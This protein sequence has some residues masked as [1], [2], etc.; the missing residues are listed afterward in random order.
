MRISTFRFF[1]VSYAVLLT[2]CGS[3]VHRATREFADNLTTAILNQDDPATV[4]DGVPSYL[5]LID[6][7]I[8]G[9]P[10]S[11]DALLAGA[12]LYGAY[13]SGFVDSTARAQHLSERAY[14][15]AKRA[16]CLREKDLC[17]ALDGPFD[18][19]QVALDKSNRGDVETIYGFASAWAGRIQVNTG[20]WNAIAD[21]PKLQALLTRL[22]NI[23]AQYDNGGAY[24]Y[25]GVI[26]SI[27]P[28]SLGGKPE[29]GK[30][31]FEKALE[32]SHGKNQ[33]VRV[34]Y[35]QFY[36]RLVFDQE[37]HDKLLNEVLAADPVVPK[38]TLINTL[39]KIKAK[40]LLES[41]KDYF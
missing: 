13:A 9:D 2:A 5:L 30:A 29:E 32:L 23:N 31:N 16:L 25:L 34:L 40:A 28:A 21:L 10:N 7:I 22:A 41:G 4:H 12:K 37:L 11:A 39:A 27:R 24:L 20:D 26:N 3:V 36:A 19:F 17:Q 14:G 15:Y 8:D 38:L 35:A 1:F 18:A 33:M 6:G